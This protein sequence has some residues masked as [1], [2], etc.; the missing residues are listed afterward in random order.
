MN[1]PMSFLLDVLLF[2]GLFTDSDTLSGTHE[3]GQVAV[4]LFLREL[5]ERRKTTFRILLYR[6][7][8]YLC[9][10]YCVLIIEPVHFIRADQLQV[11][12]A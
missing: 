12:S 11:A 8:Q 7:S 9:A 6:D 4:K 3:F 5:C 10:L 2:C 1:P